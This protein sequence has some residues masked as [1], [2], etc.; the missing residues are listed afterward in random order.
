[1]MSLYK[2]SSS[3][4]EAQSQDYVLMWQRTEYTLY[5]GS[6]TME[7]KIFG[8]EAEKVFGEER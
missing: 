3:A 7:V 6:S 8:R 2:S 1:M 5:L 4:S